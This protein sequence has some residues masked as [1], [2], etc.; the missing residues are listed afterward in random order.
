MTVG[1]R[2]NA[3][4]REPDVDCVV[5]TETQWVADSDEAADPPTTIDGETEGDDVDDTDT[6]NVVEPLPEGELDKEGDED[7]VIDVDSDRDGLFVLVTVAVTDELVHV[8]CDGVDVPDCEGDPDVD[9]V[10]R[11]EKESDGDFDCE[12]VT[13]IVGDVD[14]TAVRLFEC[15]MERVTEFV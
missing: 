7:D 11:G 8:E 13:D 14:R 15:V 1:D 3:V 5:V 10:F 9:D 12:P 6:E 4:E 2:E